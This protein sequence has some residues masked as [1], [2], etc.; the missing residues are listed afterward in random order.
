MPKLPR[1]ASKKAKRERMD[2]EM[3]KFGAG[4]MHS[5]T[6]RKGEKRE[7]PVA[8]RSQAIAIALEESGQSR[9]SKRKGRKATRSTGRR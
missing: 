1:S 3:H 7:E 4:E 6:G 9:D 2:A 8:K 5:G